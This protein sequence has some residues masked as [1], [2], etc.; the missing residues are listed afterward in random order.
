MH[1]G[2]VI[3]ALVTARELYER[4]RTAAGEL[5]DGREAASIA[6]LVL[7]EA[8]GVTRARMLADPDRVISHDIDVEGIAGQLRSGRPVQYILGSADFCG[9]KF[10]VGEGVLIPRPET[11]ELVGWILSE[12]KDARR[13][14]DIGTGCGAIAV[15]LAG[16]MPSASVRATDISPQ[17][18]EAARGNA[19]ANGVRVELLRADILAAPEEWEGVWEAGVYDFV[20][21]NPPYIPLSDTPEMH[22]NVRGYEPHTAL[23]V[24][25]ADPLVFYR[26]I[27][28]HALWM[29]RPGGTLYFEIYEGF[30]RQ[31]EELLV[32]LGYTDIEVRKDINAKPRMVR[33]RRR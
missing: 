4:V 10:S 5:Y 12:E 21:S 33:C 22:V 3:F 25:D 16:R 6:A 1:A 20:V 8:A 23:F 31:T 13:I 14:L 32:G 17:A 27:G 9:L 26:A 30:A 11:E 28:R 2:F 7:E 24:P 29:L 15:T 19:G 18:L